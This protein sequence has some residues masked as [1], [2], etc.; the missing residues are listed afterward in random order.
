MKN[1]KL[2][3][4]LSAAITMTAMTFSCKQTK[5]EQ[6]TSKANDALVYEAK[7]AATKLVAAVN[8]TMDKYEYKVFDSKVVYS[9][10][11]LCI[12]HLKVGY[13]E[14]TASDNEYCYLS[15]RQKKYELLGFVGNVYISEDEYKKSNNG[16]SYDETIFRKAVEEINRSGYLVGEPFRELKDKIALD[17][18][19][20]NWDIANYVDDFG[21]KDG[22]HFLALI[23]SG[24]F[25]N[26][27]TTNSPLTVVLSYDAKRNMFWFK[28][29]EY[30]QTLIRDNN[31]YTYKIKD[32]AGKYGN[33]S[34]YC[35]D[36]GT[37]EL[38]LE[39]DSAAYAM[40]LKG[41]LRDGEMS[42]NVHRQSGLANEYKFKLNVT[43]FNEAVK[44]LYGI[45]LKK[46]MAKYLEE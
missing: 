24:V 3:L 28:L 9:S 30:N 42:F 19:M 18:E 25:S 31:I 33:A 10:D 2:L 16:K 23:G 45:D 17:Y 12:L 21:D 15:Y 35:N 38:T 13:D 44:T 32:S 36:N 14:K 37:M 1:F 6:I 29:M 4:F 27:A 20:G 40:V 41:A 26:T 43:G 8:S 46:N 11:S 7:L 34:L 22:G 39:K 5:S